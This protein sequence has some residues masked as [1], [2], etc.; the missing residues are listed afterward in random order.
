MYRSTIRDVLWVLPWRLD[1]VGGYHE[2]MAILGFG[3]YTLFGLLIGA[4]IGLAFGLVRNWLR[5]RQ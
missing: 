5:P 2:Q 3:P 4:L 1:F